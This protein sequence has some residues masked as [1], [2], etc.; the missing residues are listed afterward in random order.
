ML[1]YDLRPTVLWSD[2]E[3]PS[4]ERG[5]MD[6]RRRK[7]RE[8]GRESARVEARGRVASLSPS[9]RET[10]N[11][12]RRRSAIMHGWLS[13]LR[14]R[15]ERK[16]K[17]EGGKTDPSPSI[18]LGRTSPRVGAGR[19]PPPPPPLLLLPKPAPPPP[20]AACELGGVVPAATA[21]IMRGMGGNDGC[22]LSVVVVVV[23]PA[24]WS[25]VVELL[26][27]GAEDEAEDGGSSEASISISAS[28]SA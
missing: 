22:P 2:D 4:S 17:K 20:P 27:G 9:R 25:A 28:P 6:E 5:Q 1:S 21:G 26:S 3:R 8:A 13:N 23:P 24:C 15:K 14:R 16:G 7:P 19:P 12:T 11:P 10:H 18:S